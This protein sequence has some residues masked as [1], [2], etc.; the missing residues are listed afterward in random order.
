MKAEVKKTQKRN[1]V[2]LAEIVIGN[3]IFFELL[4]HF[5]KPMSFF[6]LRKKEK[7]LSQ[8]RENVI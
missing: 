6:K 8:L 1:Q 7:T 2:V 4:K 5:P 3:T